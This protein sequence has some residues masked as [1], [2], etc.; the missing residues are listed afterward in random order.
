MCHRVFGGVDSVCDKEFR[1]GGIFGGCQMS[2]CYHPFL[3]AQLVRSWWSPTSA[4]RKS[5][6]PDFIRINAVFFSSKPNYHVVFLV[7]GN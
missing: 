4:S 6:T 3:N 5:F 2:L 1:V 7:L